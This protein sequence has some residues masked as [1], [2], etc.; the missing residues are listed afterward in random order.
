MRSVVLFV[1]WSL[2]LQAG[3]IHVA[4]AANVGFVM[5]ELLQSFAKVAPNTH[6]EVSL[7]SS[8]KLAA[9]IKR[10]APYDLFLSADMYYPRA[11]YEK[12]LALTRPLVYAKGALVLFSKK[13][14]KLSE[15]SEASRIAIANPKTAPYGKAAVEVLKNLGLYDK[16]KERLIYGESVAQT[17]SYALRAADV[18]F[19]A[20]SAMYS[21][22]MGKLKE[23]FIPID[24]ALYH[25]I[26]QG[27]VM[28][29]ANS[30]ANAFFVFLF[31][32]EAVAIFKKYG[33]IVDD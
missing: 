8:G 2:L 17:T 5:P 6:V 4:V 19:V 21:K 24:P 10:G 25:P 23:H 20:K 18:G 12:N 14:K 1:L 3:T 26:E 33:Y 30:D 22:A 29:K 32:K 9:Q 31:S 11:L 16:L 28:L 27:V 13:I 15:I 7:G